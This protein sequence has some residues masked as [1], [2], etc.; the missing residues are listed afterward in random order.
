MRLSTIFVIRLTFIVTASTAGASVSCGNDL[1]SGAYGLRI[2][3][4]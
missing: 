4:W 2:R 3:G 1:L